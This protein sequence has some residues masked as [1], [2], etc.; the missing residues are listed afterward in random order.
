[1][2]KGV[3]GIGV[4]LLIFVLYV[5][6]VQAEDFSPVSMASPS[7][8]RDAGAAVYSSPSDWQP[9]GA[10]MESLNVPQ[11]ES[12]TVY[13]S[14][15]TSETLAVPLGMVHPEESLPQDSVHYV[16]NSM[17]GKVEQALE[18]VE[19]F[20]N[21]WKQA[22][23]GLLYT[24]LDGAA[25][26]K[27]KNTDTTKIVMLSGQHGSQKAVDLAKGFLED[28]FAE[29]IYTPLSDTLKTTFLVESYE[30]GGE[31][32]AAQRF[33]EVAFLEKAGEKLKVSM[34]DPVSNPYGKEN[35]ETSYAA[36]TAQKVNI[37]LDEVYFCAIASF[38]A[39]GEDQERVLG[40]FAQER[41][42]SLDEMKRSFKSA[43]E[44]L[45]ARLSTEQFKQL[46]GQVEKAIIDSSNASSKKL[47]EA[48]SKDKKLVFIYLGAAHEPAV[49]DAFGRDGWE[50]M[51]Y[52]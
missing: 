19:M 51:T 14:D 5:S 39:A 40:V 4:F 2:K 32:G 7:A 26:L 46:H 52:N 15:G 8:G 31:N 44:Q 37:S 22:G 49:Y 24:E 50:E 20:D 30:P 27:I 48:G 13:Y 17:V 34:S 36:L 45:S 11:N 41:G 47:I 12:Q 25:S 10:A 28:Y 42:I 3:C 43:G 6:I 29:N 21:A 1:M 33:K 18:E 35:L 9:A 23:A 16:F 38:V